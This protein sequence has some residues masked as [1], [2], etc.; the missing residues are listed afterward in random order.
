MGD[1]VDLMRI[2][3][4]AD[5]EMREIDVEGHEVLV[6]KV[7]GDVYVTDGRCPHMR[8]HLARGTL[9]GTILTCP[10]HGSQFDVTD[11]RVIRWTR[12]EG[13]VHSIAEFLKH[14]RPLRTYEAIVKEGRILMGG[15]KEPPSAS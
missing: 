15:E 11:G 1:Y 4:L 14:P 12:Y 9:D 2:E 3:E 10:W 8:A 6:A 13:A 7:G 5:G